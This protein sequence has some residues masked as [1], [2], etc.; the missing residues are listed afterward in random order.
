MEAFRKTIY[1]EPIQFS[2]KRCV[3]YILSN[4]IA[5]AFNIK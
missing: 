2:Y 1:I 4:S 3:I 5:K